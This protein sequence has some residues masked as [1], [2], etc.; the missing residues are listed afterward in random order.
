MKKVIL[1]LLIVILTS[2][3]I[4]C[5]SSNGES[6]QTNENK[7]VFTDEDIVKAEEM[8]VFLDEK[9]KEFEIEANAAIENGEIEVGNNEEFTKSV[10]SLGQQVVIQPF[11][12]K[13]PNSLIAKGS[14]DIA[15]TFQALS[16]EPCGFG[17]CTFDKIEVYDVDYNF[18]DTELYKSEVFELSQLIFNDI[19]MNSKDE[20][21]EESG[22]IS[23]VKTKENELTFSHVPFLHIESLDIKKIDEEYNKIQ[24]N[25]PGSEVEFEQEEF[26][27][28]AKEILE[29]YPELQ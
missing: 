9:M 2:L 8:T 1:G 7:E 18:D 11:L 21:Q 20:E 22:A 28:E 15:I 10:N 3:L 24:S 6:N 25:V 14:S 5:N 12:E 17:N 26:R 19:E 13:Y 4:A 16:T 29:L 23:F 27:D